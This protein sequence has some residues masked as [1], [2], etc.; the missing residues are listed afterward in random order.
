MKKAFFLVAMSLAGF[1]CI[2]ASPAQQ[3]II[4]A[5]PAPAAAPRVVA[6]GVSGAMKVVVPQKDLETAIRA[7]REGDLLVYAGNDNWYHIDG[8]ALQQGTRVFVLGTG[9]LVSVFPKE[10]DSDSL[11]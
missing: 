9:S 7:S 8:K 4:A 2:N 10:A 1:L 5:A 11:R 3:Q 6:A